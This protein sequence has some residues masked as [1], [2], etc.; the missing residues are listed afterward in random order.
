MLAACVAAV[1][2]GCT[3][4]HTPDPVAIA[5]TL[6]GGS[7]PVDGTSYEPQVVVA[8]L[9]PSMPGSAPIGETLRVQQPERRQAAIVVGHDAQHTFDTR[10][11]RAFTAVCDD[12]DG[13]PTA[14]TDRDAVELMML[15]RADFG[16]IGGRLSARDLQAGLRQQPLGVEL[17]ALSVAPDSPV[18]SLTHQQVRQIFTGQ[19]T[20]W[21]QLGIA[22]GSIVAVVPSERALAARAAKTLIAGDRFAA[23]CVGVASEKHVADQI[24]QN[25]GA[26][27]IVRVT[28]QPC[29]S[30][31]KLLQIDWSPPTVEAFGYGTYPFG[32]PMTLVTSGQPSGIA[33]DFL[34]FA[35][36][37]EGRALM[38]RSVLV[39]P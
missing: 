23:S 27:G 33:K 4:G 7:A 37:G 25:P 21:S 28:G 3:G 18:R 35:R 16:V 26:I 11:S 13:S 31:Q 38:G 12:V 15:G 32:V 34:A 19:V 39:M 10:M 20:S 1:V 29:E 8:S 30:G 14:C 9:F 24:L 2:A 17:F 36:S 5:L 6:Q 22:G